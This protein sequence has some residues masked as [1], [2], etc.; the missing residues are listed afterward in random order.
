MNQLNEHEALVITYAVHV[1]LQLFDRVVRDGRHRFEKKTMYDETSTDRSGRSDWTRDVNEGLHSFCYQ[2]G[3]S[4]VAVWVINV[5]HDYITDVAAS[6][7][8]VDPGDPHGGIGVGDK[9]S[10]DHVLRAC[11]A[12]RHI[13][14]VLDPSRYWLGG[15][16]GEG[17]SA[18]VESRGFA[19]YY[20]VLARGQIA[21]SVVNE[22]GELGG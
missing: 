8:L 2:P 20:D 15:L 11:L 18:A 21:G 9:E 13:R 4:R 22:D 5:F 6:E 10:G 12:Y 7:S 1:L 14:A 19:Q 17:N 3:V 16:G